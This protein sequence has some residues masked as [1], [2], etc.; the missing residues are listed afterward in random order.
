M[1]TNINV[2]IND[3][4]FALSQARVDRLLRGQTDAARAMGFFDKFKDVV[5]HGGAKQAAL[6][7]LVSQFADASPSDA[8]GTFAELSKHVVNKSDL[9]VDVS[10]PENDGKAKVQ[11]LVKGT[12]IST[13]MLDH[14]T[15]AAQL[16]KALPP[17]V[18]GALPILEQAQWLDS[19]RRP[20]SDA[21]RGVDDHSFGE[22]GV[23]KKVAM[24]SG[25]P[26]GLLRAED[27]TGRGDFEREQR[28]HDHAEQT[29]RQELKRYVSTQRKLAP[30][31]KPPN[32]SQGSYAVFD[33][34]DPQHVSAKE[35]DKDLVNLKPD[36]A[37]SVL[38]QTVDMLR[39]FYE[40]DV[41]HRDLHMHNLMVF[42]DVNDPNH[43]TLKA[44]DFGKSQIGNSQ[45]GAGLSLD[46][47]F[48]DLRYM[49]HRTAS[50]IG[51]SVMR[52]ARETV[53][54]QEGRVDKH[55]PLHR[56]LG[57]LSLG[58]AGEG[59]LHARA[60]ESAKFNELLGSVGDQLL[61]DLRQAEAGPTANRDEKVSAAFQR[62]ARVL[63]EAAVRLTLPPPAP[64][65]AMF[66]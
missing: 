44:I 5:F 36:Q 20:D 8:L 55:Y 57:Q 24:V 48:D 54:F 49:F 40:N 46:R 45:A 65:G 2:K 56:L 7:N 41:S 26:T 42:R 25:A 33:T 58:P 38:N 12:P 4:A 23:H 1:A 59:G 19:H 53:G 51:D 28:M 35:L 39:V 63:D 47:K 17:G 64:L 16:G 31:N 9:M 50:G 15:V 18:H 61:D 13:E 34:Y 52:T 11:F 21:T 30:E 6:N 22:G 43:V 10:P 66:V 3:Q 14:R 37:R 32:L 60:T 62:A 27:D 29:G